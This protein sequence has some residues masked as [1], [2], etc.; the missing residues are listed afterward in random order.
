MEAY[1]MLV[2][3]PER[4]RLLGRT[5]HRNVDNSK[6]DLGEIRSGGMDWINLAEDTDQKLA[7]VRVSVFKISKFMI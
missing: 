1:G 3:K 6:T 7:V 2:G 4:K 5:K